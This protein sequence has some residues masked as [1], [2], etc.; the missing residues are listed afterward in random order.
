[1]IPK[2]S[3]LLPVYNGE[4][5]LSSAIE[6][7]LNQEFQDFELLV[8]DDASTDGT[9]DILAQ[10]KDPRLRMWRHSENKGLVA[11]LNEL[12]VQAKAPIVA[13]QD[14]DDWSFPFRL[15]LQMEHMASHPN[16]AAIFSDAQLISEN[17]RYMGKMRTPR[18]PEAIQ[19]DLCFRNPFPH[20]SALFRRDMALQEGGYK[21]VP[22]CEDYELWSRLSRRGPIYSLEQ[23]LVKYRIHR[24]SIMGKENAMTTEAH[25]HARRE[26][27]QSN[28]RH[29]FGKLLGEDE[30]VTLLNTWH[31]QNSANWKKY[32]RVRDYLSHKFASK[33]KVKGFAELIAEEDY[34]LFCRIVKHRK[35]DA[36]NFLLSLGQSNFERLVR[37][38]W[39]RIAFMMLQP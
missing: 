30:E 36:M 20:T 18:C 28:I 3:V 6:S 8:V 35:K 37:L 24:T 17:G 15:S 10:T 31:S 13:R 7:I 16:T 4:K 34:A 29:T 19:W 1:M 23:P 27:A 26:I 22:A 5:Y 9:F 12:L 39:V 21:N 14:H 32:F 38:P 2:V 25:L 11:T 33:T